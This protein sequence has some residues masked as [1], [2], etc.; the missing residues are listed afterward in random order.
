MS[1]T[2]GSISSTISALSVQLRRNKPGSFEP[3]R[4]RRQQQNEVLRKQPEL[5]RCCELPTRLLTWLR[6]RLLKD[7]R[8]RNLL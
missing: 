7:D 8:L 1:M 5:S 4:H 2:S 3:D 6:L